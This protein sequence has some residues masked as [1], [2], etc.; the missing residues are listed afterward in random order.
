MSRIRPKELFSSGQSNLLLC[1]PVFQ[2]LESSYQKYILRNQAK[3]VFDM[4]RIKRIIDWPKSHLENPP[5]K[6]IVANRHV[7]LFEPFPMV[8]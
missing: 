5:K 8:F 4:V 3:R 2:Y 6:K 7:P 1:Q